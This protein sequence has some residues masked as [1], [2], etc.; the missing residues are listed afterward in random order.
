MQWAVGAR[1]SALEVAR[2]LAERGAKADAAFAGSLARGLLQKHGSRGPR[3][4]V[5][6]VAL[7]APQT[8]LALLMFR[9]GSQVSGD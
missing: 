9:A 4:S 6:A 2:A 3:A 7:A 5:L 1:S 8:R